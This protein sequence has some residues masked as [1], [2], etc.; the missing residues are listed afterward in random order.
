MVT[1]EYGSKFTIDKIK[2]PTLE[3]FEEWKK[4]LFELYPTE[5]LDFDVYVVGGFNNFLYDDFS[6]IDI[7]KKYFQKDLEN[8]SNEELVRLDKFL[9]GIFDIDIVLTKC[10][11]LKSIKK[12]M[13]GIVELGFK[14]Y[15]TVFDIA[16]WDTSPDIIYEN[17]YLGK[18]NCKLDNIPTQKVK[19]YLL[20]NI[21]KINGSGT[22]DDEA[23]QIEYGLWE[24]YAEYPTIKQKQLLSANYKYFKPTLIKK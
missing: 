14:K 20:S 5:L 4:D 23:K 11:N 21:L 19:A 17:C 7:N 3:M 2:P 18:E 24:R 16:F 9:C 13:T 6:D 15:Q 1:I 12:I 10:D 8:M 22:I